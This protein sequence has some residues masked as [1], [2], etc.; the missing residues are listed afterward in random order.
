MS[1]K[2][3]PVRG[4]VEVRHISEAYNRLTHE[5]MVEKK[6]L[7]SRVNER[8]MELSKANETNRTLIKK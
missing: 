7:E 4:S 8:T 5:L 2:D 3:V 6:S 1:F